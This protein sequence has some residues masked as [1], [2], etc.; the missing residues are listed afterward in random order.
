MVC[1]I[2]GLDAYDVSMMCQGPELWNPLRDQWIALVCRGLEEMM[3]G[4][5]YGGD[6]AAL[7]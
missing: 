2:A 7:R 4:W 6:C 1:R 3:P 5:A